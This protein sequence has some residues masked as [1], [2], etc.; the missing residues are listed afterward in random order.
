[1][2]VVA[3]CDELMK[4]AVLSMSA[5][6]AT[7]VARL[8]DLDRDVLSFLDE[9]KVAY[10][11]C[12]ASDLSARLD[13][14][15]VDSAKLFKHFRRLTKV[16]AANPATFGL[17]HD[18]VERL[19]ELRASSAKY[20]QIVLKKRNIL[21]HVVEEQGESGWILRGSDEIDVTDF[22]NIRRSFAEY[23]DA[24]REMQRLVT[25]LDV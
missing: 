13:T 12:L 11:A 20:D 8:S 24:F 18:Q 4:I 2:R 7:C 21:G 17:N 6:D 23:I 25:S 9:A 1:M 5:R 15:A 19:R 3:E 22:P 16:A 14:R 10:E